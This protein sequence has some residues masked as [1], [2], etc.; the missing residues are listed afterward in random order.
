VT[1]HRAPSIEIPFREQLAILV[2]VHVPRIM[3]AIQEMK[4]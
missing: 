2:D 1:L 3:I 4:T